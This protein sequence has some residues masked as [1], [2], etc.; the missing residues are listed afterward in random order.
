MTSTPPARR[1][2]AEWT[3]RGPLWF[4][5]HM[6]P[7]DYMAAN[8]Q[9]TD[10]AGIAIVFGAAAAL[11]TLGVIS[12]LAYDAGM[13]AAAFTALRA[14]L[15]ACILGTL[16]LLRLQPRT[17]IRA[18]APRE[19]R[20]FLIAIVTNGSMNLLLFAGFQAM[21]VALVMTVFYTYPLMVMVVH[22]RAA[23]RR[24]PPLA[25]WRSS[26]PWPGCCWSSV[27][28]SAQRHA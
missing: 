21:T 25:S 14:A 6:A 7:T 23:R 20:M 17:N 22:A 26:S 27:A 9:H 11:G 24:S 19:K 3:L 15:G 1:Q 5:L 16:V 10:S 2:G 8:D 28:R 12:N 13:S 18:L 4:D